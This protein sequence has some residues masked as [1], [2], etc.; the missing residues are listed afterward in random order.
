MKKEAYRC[1]SFSDGFQGVLD[2]EEMA[3]GREDCDCAIVAT[4]RGS[5][6]GTGDKLS[7]ET[8]RRIA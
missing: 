1:G 6:A 8:R 7:F 5:D 3:V 4:H 2:L